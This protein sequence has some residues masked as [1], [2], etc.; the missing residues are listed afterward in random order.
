MRR[1]KAIVLQPEGLSAGWAKL[2]EM[3]LDIEQFKQ[4][5]QAGVCLPA[6]AGNTRVLRGS[7]ADR[8]YLGPADPL[9]V[10]GLRAEMMYFKKTLDKIGVNVEIEHAGKYKD[11]GDMFT[12]S[13]MSPE[14]REVHDQRGRRSLRQPGGEHRRGAEEIA[15]RSAGHYRPGS[16]HRH[17]GAEGGAGG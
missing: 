4:I 15:G 12:R 16:V 1:I 11:F 17:A 14:T 6:P 8:I 13:D 5:G 3:R 7:G 10:K 2:E 9:M